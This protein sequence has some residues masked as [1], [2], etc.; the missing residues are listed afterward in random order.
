MNAI[1]REHCLIRVNLDGDEKGVD[2][3][4]P[5]SRSR[6]HCVHGYACMRLEGIPITDHGFPIPHASVGQ[7][8]LKRRDRHVD[9]GSSGEES[10]PRQTRRKKE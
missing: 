9:V 10:N 2:C 1:W 8:E 4:C 3:T 6:G 7:A 5:H